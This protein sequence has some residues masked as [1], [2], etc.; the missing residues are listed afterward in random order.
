MSGTN[1]GRDRIIE[2]VSASE[3]AVFEFGRSLII[4]LSRI[5]T[6]RYFSEAECRLSSVS[7][8]TRDSFSG[9]RT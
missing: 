1:P 3:G 6:E 5:P 2:L 7:E 9:L 4:R 8:V